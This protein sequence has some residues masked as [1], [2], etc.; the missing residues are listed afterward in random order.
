MIR[1][2]H[3]LTALALSIGLIT[4]PL[5]HF[6][7][8]VAAVFSM[9]IGYFVAVMEFRKHTRSF[10][11]I[12]LYFNTLVFGLAL[13]Q[14]SFFI[15]Y[16]TFM[17]LMITF[18]MTIR[19]HFS[20]FMLFTRAL[21]AEPLLLGG[22][23]ALYVIANLNSNAGWLGWTVP[24]APILYSGFDVFGKIIAGI[25]YSKAEKIPYTAEVGKPAPPFMLTDHDGNLV[26]INDYK[27]RKH[28]LL[29]F[30]RGDWC[31]ASHIMLR[32]YQRS[33]HRFREKDIAVIAIGPDPMGVNREMVE[34]LGLEFKVLADEDHEVAKTY[35]VQLQPN[36]PV[37]SY[38]EGIPMP[39]AFLVDR[40]GI[41]LYSSRYDRIGEVTSPA[42]ILPIVDALPQTI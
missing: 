21:W 18:V 33:Y 32:K 17:F 28:L 37:A 1:K 7:L 8:A 41:V 2:N 26:N 5:I 20:R 9:F 4:L 38:N 40:N 19:M 3:L 36:N 12:T 24:V 27:G 35:G 34:K 30:V 39:A 13:D 16:F 29:L 25:H 23:I 14:L 15:P 22:S 42:D 6:Q 31:P 11:F 10:Q